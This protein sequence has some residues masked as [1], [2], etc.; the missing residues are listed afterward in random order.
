MQNKPEISHSKI[1]EK[2]RLY[3]PITIHVLI[4]IIGIAGCFY[5]IFDSITEIIELLGYGLIPAALF[6]IF[7]CH[8]GISP[9]F[10]Q[11]LAVDAGRLDVLIGVIILIPLL[12]SLTIQELLAW[13]G[14][15]FLAIGTLFISLGIALVDSQ[16]EE[17]LPETSDS[18]VKTIWW[19]W[20]P[21][22]L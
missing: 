17:V 8:I 21:D 9:L 22:Q 12:W 7:I 3:W 10:H 16:N 13:D 18:T 1:I 4:Y 2:S 11:E 5:L 6:F 19:P 20:G 14:L 15:F